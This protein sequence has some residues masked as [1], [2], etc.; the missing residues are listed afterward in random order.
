MAEQE[1]RT[2]AKRRKGAWGVI[3]HNPLIS[4]VVAGLVVLFVSVPVSLLILDGDDGSSG[5]TPGASNQPVEPDPPENPMEEVA[6]RPFWVEPPET[7]EDADVEIGDTTQMFLGD[8]TAVTPRELVESAPEYEGRSIYLVGKVIAE[9]PLGDESHIGD[10]YR[11]KGVADH[12]DAYIGTDLG[13]ALKGEVIYALGR[14]AARGESRSFG[15]GRFQTAYFLSLG[16]TEFDSL[17]YPD[18]V[19]PAIRQAAKGLKNPATAYG[20]PSVLP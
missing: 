17:T 11:I 5:T 20:G 8:V 16:S 12:F 18:S 19:A 4:S 1:E 3:S 10:E 9:F 7:F 14:V 2:G 6:Q 13:V 15:E